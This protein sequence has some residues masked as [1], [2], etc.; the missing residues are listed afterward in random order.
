MDSRYFEELFREAL[1]WA[2]DTAGEILAADRLNDWDLELG[3]RNEAVEIARTLSGR[4]KRARELLRGVPE[5]GAELMLTVFQ[6]GA[7]VAELSELQPMKAAASARGAVNANEL[8]AAI[9]KAALEATHAHLGASI[10]PVAT[11]NK[12]PPP[13]AARAAMAYELVL[14]NDLSREAAREEV[15]KKFRGRLPDWTADNSVWNA[16]K[17]HAKRNGLPLPPQREPG[18]RGGE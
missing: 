17:R 15:N 4:L 16:A 3:I 18:R 7:G 13:T 1:D 12:N 10:S 5:R 11:A 8:A 6:I 14:N 9:A 2:E